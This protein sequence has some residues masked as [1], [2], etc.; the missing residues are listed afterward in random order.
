MSAR[1]LTH[2]SVG[3]KYGRLTVVSLHRRRF[4]KE[5]FED[6]A[7]CNCECGTRQHVVRANCLFTGHT[8]SCGC[9]VSESASKRWTTHGHS[10]KGNSRTYRTWKN[11]KQRCTNPNIPGYKNYGGRGIVI[12]DR[13]SKSFS[14]FLEDMGVSPAG[15]FIDR[16]NNDGNYEPGNCRWANRAM[17]N[18]NRRSVILV[19]YQ[20][21][22]KT[23]VEWSRAVGMRYGLIKYRYHAGWP[24]DLLL[25]TPA[26]PRGQK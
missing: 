22:T 23:L 26:L 7:V 18:R 11:M 3:K 9:Y 4:G 15:A 13:W 8:K 12:C 20:G 21:Q 14:A 5:C 25:T 2:I 19:E 17:Q 16:I 10:K 24:T 1:K 6:A